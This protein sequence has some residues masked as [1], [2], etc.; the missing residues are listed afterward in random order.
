MGGCDKYPDWA[1]TCKAIA[2][3]LVTQARDAA[4]SGQF[5]TQQCRKDLGCPPTS[6]EAIAVASEKKIIEV[7]SEAWVPCQGVIVDQVCEIVGKQAVEHCADLGPL[8]DRGCDKY[9]DWAATC[10]AIAQPLVTQACDAAGSGQ[11]DTQQC[12][13]ALGCPSTSVEAILV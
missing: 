10:K 13:K 3:P 2:Q 12:R 4:G 9:P 1:A 7:D 11:F 5:D 8:V 6:V